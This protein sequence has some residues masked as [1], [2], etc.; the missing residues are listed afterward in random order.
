[1]TET[2]VVLFAGLPL[3]LLLVDLG[4]TLVRRT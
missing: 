2:A 1:M 3:A 4:R